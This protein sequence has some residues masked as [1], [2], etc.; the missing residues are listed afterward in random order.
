MTITDES[1]HTETYT[2]GDAYVIPRGF[3]GHFK[4]TGDY[5]NYFITVEPETKG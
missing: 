3:K 4:M 1:G 5:K 2:A